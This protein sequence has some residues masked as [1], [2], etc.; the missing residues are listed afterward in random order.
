MLTGLED[1][2]L[3][4]RPDRIYIIFDAGTGTR[5]SS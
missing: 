4:P 3:H 5:S 2:R 1:V